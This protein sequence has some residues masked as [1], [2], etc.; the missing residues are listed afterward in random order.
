MN[1]CDGVR[2]AVDVAA[3][4][5]NPPGWDLLEYRGYRG[6]VLFDAAAGEF[7]GRLVNVRAIVT[8]VGRSADEVKAAFRDSVEDHLQWAVEEGREPEPPGSGPCGAPYLTH[9]P[10]HACRAIEAA[11]HAAGQSVGEWVAAR[12]VEAVA[13]PPEPHRTPKDSQRTVP[14]ATAARA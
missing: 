8:F 10:Y 3:D 5:A 2:A 12:A 14:N 1:D 6:S 7:H 4:P 13:D 9:L 11:A